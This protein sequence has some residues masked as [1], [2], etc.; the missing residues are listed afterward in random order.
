MKDRTQTKLTVKTLRLIGHVEHVLAMLRDEWPLTLRQVY[1][2]LVGR[3]VLENTPEAYSALGGA[4]VKARLQ[5]LVPW[6]AIE[7]R[8]RVTLPSGGWPDAAAFKAHEVKGFLAGYR[9]DLLQGQAV[10]LEVWTEKDALSRMLHKVAYPYCVPV[11]IS[12]GFPS[13]S[14]VHEARL[15]VESGA[16]M[17]QQ[18]ILLHFGDFDPSGEAM[19]APILRT[20]QVEMGLGDAVE[21]VRCALTLEQIREHD[22]PI[23]VKAI[24]KGDTR[25]PQHVA[26]YGK[27]AVELDALPPAALRHLVQ[28]A[29]EERLDMAAFDEEQ[30]T[31]DEERRKLVHVHDRVVRLVEGDDET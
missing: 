28:T 12:R 16:D 3:L 20:L 13:I 2:Q 18:T 23:S 6:E 5:G 27:V 15:R 21:G 4:I 30:Q 29:I 9:R 7:D 24:K 1:Y 19:L 10:A 14:L 26:K 31:E 8:V 25:T 22:L 11:V 17:G